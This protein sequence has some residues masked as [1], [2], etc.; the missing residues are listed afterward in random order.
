MAHVIYLISSVFWIGLLIGVSFIATPV[1]FLAPSLTRPVAL[2][3]GRVTFAIWNDIEWLVLALLV[4]SLVF[5]NIDHFSAV[6]TFVLGILLL[7]QS[8]VLLPVLNERVMVIQSGKHPPS[9]A[10]HRNYIVIDIV[11]LCIL[12]AIVWKQSGGIATLLL[13]K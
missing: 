1:K 12:A 5:M 6:A 2:D 7:L 4:P 8:A 3:V 13:T 9:S 11:K 10:D